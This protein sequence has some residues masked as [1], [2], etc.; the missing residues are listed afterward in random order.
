MSERLKNYDLLRA[1]C[2]LSVII[3][4]IA[5]VYS[6]NKEIIGEYSDAAFS[7]CDFFQLITRYAVPCFV[8]LSGA[9]ILTNDK[10]IDFSRFYKHSFIKVGIPTILFSLMYICCRIVTK[11]N[12]SDIVIDTLNG[13]PIGH[14]WYLFM[15]AGLY[16]VTPFIIWLR[17][18]ISEKRFI[19]VSVFLTLFGVLVHYTCQI[20]WPIQFLEYVGYFCLGCCIKEKSTL[21]KGSSIIYILIGLFFFFI[22]FLLNENS[23]HTAL[24]DPSFFRSNSFPTIVVGSILFFIGFSKIRLKSLCRPI[25][26]IS[27]YSLE[28]YI[29]HPLAFGGL[30]KLVKIKYGTLPNPYWYVPVNI[31]FTIITTLLLS[32]IYKKIYAVIMMSLSK[33]EQNE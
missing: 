19:Y 25:Q 26:I 9:F 28:I 27:D 4:H 1:I 7:F 22:T 16:A 17:K 29:L 30:N 13:R 6:D 14:M 32:V 3:M 12:F 15:L 8:M 10:N 5:A 23:F 20:I 24:Y 11:E 31:I 18:N 2:C 21:I 33:E